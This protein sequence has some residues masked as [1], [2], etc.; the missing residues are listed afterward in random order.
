ML[1]IISSKLRS[2][3]VGVEYCD[4]VLCTF[5]ENNQTEIYCERIL[6]D[7]EFWI[8]CVTKFEEFLKVSILPEC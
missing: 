4:F 1:I 5:P 6:V 7:Q 3:C 2:L 8:Q